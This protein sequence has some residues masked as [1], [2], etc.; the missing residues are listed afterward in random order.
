MD[1]KFKLDRRRGIRMMDVLGSS[2]GS[3]R[4][5]PAWST[6]LCLGGA[7]VMELSRNLV[8]VR[9]VRLSSPGTESPLP[10]T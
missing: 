4:E 2:M 1:F 9:A 7:G 5:V 10:Y 3:G 8:P 6:K